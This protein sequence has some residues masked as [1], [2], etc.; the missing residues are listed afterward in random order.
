MSCGRSWVSAVGVWSPGRWVLGG[1]IRNLW[2]FGGQSNRPSVNTFLLQPFVNF[3]FD[4][5]W[6]E[7]VIYDR[8]RLPVGRRHLVM[9]ASE[10]E[11][12]LAQWV[13]RWP[14]SLQGRFRL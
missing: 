9:T 3:N 1:L 10:L 11:A 14:P 12:S 6:Y 4:G 2:S 5:G 8:A 13:E 7:T